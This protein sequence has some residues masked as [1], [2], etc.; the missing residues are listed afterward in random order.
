[1]DTET[2][3]NYASRDPR[4]ISDQP[5]T[6]SRTIEHTY[7]ANRAGEIRIPA[8]SLAVVDPA[9]GEQVIRATEATSIMVE[10]T[11]GSSVALSTNGSGTRPRGTA[12]T[13]GSEGILFIDEGAMTNGTLAN[14]R[15]PLAASPIFWGMHLL[16]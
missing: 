15:R 10:A 3:N 12:R 6:S 13:L 2:W 9:T 14:A 5:L 4:R 16:P 8:I 11:E 7:L 1:Q